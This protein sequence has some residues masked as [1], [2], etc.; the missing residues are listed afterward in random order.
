[1]DIRIKISRVTGVGFCLLF[2]V[3]KPLPPFNP[4][5]APFV[6]TIVEYHDSLYFST[7]PGGIYRMAPDRHALPIRLG[8]LKQ[9]HPIRGLAFKH[10]GSLFASSYETG[11]QRVLADTCI[12]LPTMWRTAWS[13]K[14]DGADNIWLASR[15]G[16]FRQHGDTLV[17]FTDLHEAH[18]IDFYYGTCAIAH[19]R[20]ITLYDTASETPLTTFCKGRVCWSIDVYD[21][22]LIGTGKEACILVTPHD[23]TVIGIG[24]RH[25]I[26]WSAVRSPD[27]TIYL[28]TQKGLLRIRPGQQKAE[29]VAFKGKC[30][31]SLFIDKKGELWVGRYFKGNDTR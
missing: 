25:N 18:D 17:R 20:G 26:P 19:S 3:C 4:V 13:M 7:Q 22:L 6:Y 14:L 2:V 31:K 10:D 9:R 11:V 8:G 5:P 15:Q 24:P 1:M 27:G 23:T 16:V 28:G 29:C 12:P 21:S 30:I